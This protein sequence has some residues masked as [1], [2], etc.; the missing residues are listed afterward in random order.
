MMPDANRGSQHNKSIHKF[1]MLLRT[2]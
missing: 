1:N 2:C